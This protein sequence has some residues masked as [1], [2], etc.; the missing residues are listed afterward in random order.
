MNLPQENL[1]R[2]IDSA[3]AT[4][5]TLGMTVAGKPKYPVL[6]QESKQ[7]LQGW[8]W[9]LDAIGAALRLELMNRE[10]QNPMDLG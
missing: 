3:S 4:L 7:R 9:D 8:L 1:E 10:D 2:A 5:Y 6:E